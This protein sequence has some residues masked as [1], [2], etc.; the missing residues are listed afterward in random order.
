LTLLLAVA[1]LY[2]VEP[3]VTWTYEALSEVDALLE[4]AEV[5]SNSSVM[6]WG[7]AIEPFALS[8]NRPSTSAPL[9]VVLS[10]GAAISRVLEL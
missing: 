10:D 5:T 1:T 2:P 7:A 8:P 3:C 9:A 4:L 6:P